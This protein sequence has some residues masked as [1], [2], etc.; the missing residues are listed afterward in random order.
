MTCTDSDSEVSSMTGQRSD[1]HA[2]RE[3]GLLDH[4]RGHA[5]VEH[6]APSI[7][8]V[9]NTRLV[10]NPRESLTRIGVL[11]SAAT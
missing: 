5:L 2:G 4:G 9:P 11:P 1:R 3:R 7:T 10:K 6:R 8:N